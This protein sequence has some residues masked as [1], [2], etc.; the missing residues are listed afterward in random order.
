[1]AFRDIRKQRKWLSVEEVRLLVLGL[2]ILVALFFANLYLARTLPGGEWF[3]QRWSGARVFLLEAI[4][5]SGGVKGARILPDATLD[6]VSNVTSPYSTEIARRTQELVYGRPAFSS[7]YT[8]VLNDPFF[9]LLLYSP[10]A[11]ISDFVLARAIWMLASEVILFIT[12]LLAFN[13][14]EWQPRPWLYVFLL[15]FGIF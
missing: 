5:F 6:I 13:L 8:Y 4:Q 15:V 11:L 10:L 3:F 14:A 1:M 12:V 7:D 2:I 9:I